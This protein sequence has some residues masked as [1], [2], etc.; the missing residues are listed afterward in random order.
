MKTTISIENAEFFAYHGYY[1]QERRSGNTFII[2]C[3]VEVKSFD[4]MDDNI[5]DTVNYEGL[6]SICKNQ[7]EETQLLLE[8][9]VLRIIQDIRSQ[10]DHVVGGKVKLSK[11]G[12]Q[13]G[14]KVDKA[15]VEMSW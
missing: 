11:V 2:D 10:Y 15:T 12:P 5:N 13:L 3:E 8:T 14:G 1:E 6:Y 7:M 4:S 9:V